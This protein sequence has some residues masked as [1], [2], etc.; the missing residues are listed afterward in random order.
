MSRSAIE[1]HAHKYLGHLGRVELKNC[2]RE[3]DGIYG[4][5]VVLTRSDCIEYYAAFAGSGA[6][7]MTRTR[8]EPL[9]DL[10]LFANRSN[11]QGDSL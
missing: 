8:T 3:A 9:P 6:V 10:P 7:S 11:P 5:I 1:K 4:A 2:H